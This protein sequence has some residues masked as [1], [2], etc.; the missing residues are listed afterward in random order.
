MN[1][2]RRYVGDYQR[3]TMH[4]SLVE[5][6]V[7]SV[8]LDA[9]YS[10][11]GKIPVTHAELF[12]LCR[13]FDPA[14]RD[15]VAKI[16]DEYFPINGDGNR[17]NKRADRELLVALPAIDRMREAGKVGASKRW[18]KNGVEMGSPMGNPTKNDGE[19]YRV[20][21]EPPTS[22]HHPPSTTLDPPSAGSQPPKKVKNTARGARLALNG[23]PPEWG[24]WTRQERPDINPESVFEE[25]RDYWQAIAGSK[26]VKL[27]WFATWRNWCRRQNGSGKA[28]SSA[29]AAREAERLIFG[30][31]ERVIE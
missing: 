9:Y 25:F 23:L 2:Y 19:P 15:A 1:Y 14:E 26:G 7:Y 11:D 18:A 28:G 5:H 3:D 27:D 8:L 22:I 12:R 29:S 24:A 4:L 20:A 17:H 21:I 10:R 13:A 6:G 31:N 30:N 16:S